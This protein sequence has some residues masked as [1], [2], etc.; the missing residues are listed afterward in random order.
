MWK[1]KQILIKLNKKQDIIIKGTLTM[2]GCFFSATNPYN[3]FWLKFD[4]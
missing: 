1:Q 3:G 2:L 4:V